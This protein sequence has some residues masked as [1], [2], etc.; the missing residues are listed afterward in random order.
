MGVYPH[1]FIEVLRDARGRS[2][3]LRAHRQASSYRRNIYIY[4]YIY[5]CIYIHNSNY[6]ISVLVFPTPGLHNKIPA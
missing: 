1:V 5:I 6:Y 2:G 3:D 4:I